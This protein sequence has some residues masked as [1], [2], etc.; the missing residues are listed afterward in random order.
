ME[1]SRRKIDIKIIVE[2]DFILLTK[3]I[4]TS[5]EPSQRPPLDEV[6]QRLDKFV[7]ASKTKV[8]ALL[9]LKKN[10][11]DE[12]EIVYETAPANDGIKTEP[13]YN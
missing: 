5:F 11:D 8:R 4:V 13:V 1:I 3:Y 9:T 7:G 6:L 12:E 10:P 2:S